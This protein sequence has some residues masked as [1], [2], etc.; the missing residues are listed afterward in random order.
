MAWCEGAGVDHL[1]SAVCDDALRVLLERHEH[2]PP[3]SPLLFATDPRYQPP[4]DSLSGPPNP[5]TNE[6]HLRLAMFSALVSNPL[7][8]RLAASVVLA[9]STLWDC[10]APVAI[11][12]EASGDDARAR[13]CLGGGTTLRA[14]EALAVGA[15]LSHGRVEVGLGAVL[16]H[17][18]VVGTGS[19]GGV[20]HH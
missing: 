7:R 4:Q 10:D 1:L 5:T 17:V 18:V 11:C 16:G 20:R 8:S 3:L 12:S 13:V 15:G 6:T 2:Q 14:S 19:T 9:P